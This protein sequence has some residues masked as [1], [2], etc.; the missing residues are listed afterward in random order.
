MGRISD[1]KS[2]FSKSVGFY[3]KAILFSKFDPELFREIELKGFLS[4]ALIMSGDSDR[5]Y[6]LARETFDSFEK[7]S[8]GEKL[9]RSDYQTWAIWRSGIV[10]RT[11]EAFIT[12]KLNYNKKEFENWLK[13][14][15]TDLEKG[16]FS[17]R[18]AEIKIL[19]Q[20]LLEN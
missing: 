5:G 9:K 14:A 20:K 1:Y 3:K 18:K 4:Y 19:K 6:K 7:S 16:D 8:D 15:E 12:K 2:E 10:I 17:Y 13:T 11:I